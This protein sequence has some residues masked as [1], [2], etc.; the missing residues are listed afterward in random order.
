M[1]SRDRYLPPFLGSLVLACALAAVAGAQSHLGKE[2]WVAQPANPAPGFFVVITNPGTSVANLTIFNVWE[3][4]NTGSVP[5]GGV[6]TFNF[7][8]HSVVTSGPTTSTDPV[9]H[10]TSDR[11]VGVVVF[12]PQGPAN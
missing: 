5:A 3:G 8:D 4:T 2:F 9:Y 11:E 1:S 10:I 6:K 7:P 12:D